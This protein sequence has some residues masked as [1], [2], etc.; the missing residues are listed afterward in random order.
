MNTRNHLLLDEYPLLVYPRLA[1]LIGLNESI[2]L[3]QFHYWLD[4]STHQHNGKL[5]VYNTYEAWQEQFPFWSISTIRRIIGSLEKCGLIITGNYNHAG[6]DKTKWYTIDYAELDRM[7]NAS[8]QNEQTVNSN[9]TDASLSLNKP[10]PENTSKTTPERR[11]MNTAHSNPEIQTNFTALN[12][13]LKALGA[14]SDYAFTKQTLDWLKI[15]HAPA[16]ALLAL[17]T[18]SGW[19]S[20]KT[21]T[22]R[23]S[24]LKI[25]S[26]YIKQ[27]ESFPS[28][29]ELNWLENKRTSDNV[30]EP[31]IVC[32]AIKTANANGLIA[33]TDTF[34]AY[35]VQA[36]QQQKE[37]HLPRTSRQL[38]ATKADNKPS[39]FA[40]ITGLFE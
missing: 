4:K 40:D 33:L 35:V 11:K 17:I 8:V 27:Y 28:E 10:I 30:Y 36:S 37:K 15:N 12:S 7:S 1:C 2:I 18:A 13:Y 22:Q 16:S 24:M 26:V 23:D 39:N 9:W 19:R 38:T 14:N 34:H 32:Q 20:H 5:W 6:F 29:A 21:K 31:K 25:L 3:Q